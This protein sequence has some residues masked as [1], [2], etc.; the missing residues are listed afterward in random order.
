M[1]EKW[2]PSDQGCHLCKRLLEGGVFLSMHYD[3]ERLFLFNCN[4]QQRTGKARQIVDK[5]GSLSTASDDENFGFEQ[6]GSIMT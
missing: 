1:G 3:D 5:V 2:H 4:A 6:P